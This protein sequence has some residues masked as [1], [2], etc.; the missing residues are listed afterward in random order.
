MNDLLNIRIQTYIGIDIKCLLFFIL[1]KNELCQ[2]I[3]VEIPNIKFSGNPS[4]G[5]RDVECGHTERQTNITDQIVTFCSCF[6]NVLNLLKPSGNFT[7]RQ[8]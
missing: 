4:G 2:Q 8:V 7:Y 5:G 6:A 3:V 1:T